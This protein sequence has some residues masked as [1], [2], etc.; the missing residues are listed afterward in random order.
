VDKRKISIIM[1]VVLALVAVV[2]VRNYISQTEKKYIREEKKAYVLVATQPIAAGATIDESMMK[3]EAIPEK[4]VQPN[5]VNS[6]SLA[7]GRRAAAAIAPGEQIMT[8]KLTLAVK[9]TSLAMRTPQGKRAITITVPFLAAVGGKIRTSDYVDLIGTFPYNAQVDGRTVTEMV[10]VTLFQN[11]L[12]LG[13]E[14]GAGVPA[15]RGQPAVAP[16]DLIIMLALAPREAAL[17]SF[18]LEQKASLRL[19]LRPPLETSIEPVPPVEVNALW[20]YVFS[21]LGQEFMATK[22][23]PAGMKSQEKKEE[24]PPP[25]TVE[26]FRGTEK[27]NMIM[28]K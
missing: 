24:P 2:M 15:Q 6:P 14:G 12:I 23:E 5:A 27:S 7:A 16:T 25:P 3:M 19:V 28:N 9:D 21:N 22:E 17:L 26:I 13:V 8:T 1:A 10:S 11:V 4:Y 20:Q 18:A